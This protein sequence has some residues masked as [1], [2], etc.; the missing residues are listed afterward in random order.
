[1]APTGDPST[2]DFVIDCFPAYTKFN[3]KKKV[4]AVLQVIDQ[5]D[6]THNYLDKDIMGHGAPNDT[7]QTRTKDSDF[8]KWYDATIFSQ[9]SDTAS[10]STS[11]GGTTV[12]P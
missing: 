4:Q 2:F 8:D 5:T 9:R 12:N 11:G 6:S 1:M 10:S 3:R 7:T